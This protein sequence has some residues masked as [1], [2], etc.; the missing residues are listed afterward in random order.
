MTRGARSPAGR[1]TR[2]RASATSGQQQPAQHLNICNGAELL[3]KVL[4][5]KKLNFANVFVT[6]TSMCFCVVRKS[7][8]NLNKTLSMLSKVGI[9]NFY[10]QTTRN[11]S[12]RMIALSKEPSTRRRP[13]KGKLRECSFRAL[14]TLP[15][16]GPGSGP[17]SGSTPRSWRRAAACCTARCGGGPWPRQP[18][19][20]CSRST[21]L[22]DHTSYSPFGFRYI[23]LRF[24][25]SKGVS[26]FFTSLILTCGRGPRGRSSRS[27]CSQ[28]TI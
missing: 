28:G 2:R 11:N 8:W 13:K 1:W 26:S 5:N 3:A 14:L 22:C 15:C 20:S 25:Y 21:Y 24:Q 9:E 27:V 17:G 16:S 19:S 23:F 4:T 18:S 12:T 6:D 10:D 7:F